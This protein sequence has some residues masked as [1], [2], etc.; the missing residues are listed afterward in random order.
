MTNFWPTKDM[1][2]YL[3]LESRVRSRMALAD[4]AATGEDDPLD[5]QEELQLAEK[6]LTLRYKQLRKMK[7]EG[8][9]IEELE[10]APAMSDFS[11]ARFVGQL[12]E[13]LRQKE[14]E[15]RSMPDGAYAV[16]KQE[17]GAEPGI[18]FFLRQTNADPEN[19]DKSAS[20]LAPHYAV[21]VQDDGTIRHGC[22]NAQQILDIFEAAAVGK[23]EP[24]QDMCDLF[25]M[26]TENGQKMKRYDALVQAAGRHIKSAYEDA[27]RKSMA[28]GDSNFLLPIT[29]NAPRDLNDFTLVT[30][31][32]ILNP[33]EER[34]QTGYGV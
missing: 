3:N 19:P 7:E 8:A 5:I 17:E 2:V 9:Y 18:L 24:I 26:E 32:V 31:L 30:W 33:D 10:D 11:F 29:K 20:P 21:Y 16:I 23:T 13:Y 14:Y 1:E 27:V 4:I 25:N 22:A 28:D 15:L 6:E 34:Y 12:K